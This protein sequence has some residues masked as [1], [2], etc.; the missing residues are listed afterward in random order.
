[1]TEKG[2]SESSNNIFQILKQELCD[3]TINPGEQLQESVVCERFNA[4][5]PPVRTAF[6]RLSDLGLVDIIPYRGVFS[7]L[8]DLDYIY[9]MIHLRINIESR[10]IIDFIDSHP[11]PLILEEIEHNIRKQKILIEKE[12]VNKTD[13]F[14]LDS[15]MHSI[16]F[17]NRRCQD[18]WNIIQQQEIH[19]TRFR[20]LD[21][22]ETQKYS[23][24]SGD[25]EK[26][27]QAIKAEKPETVV[28]ILGTHLNG[29][30]RRMGPK[31][32]NEYGSFFKA[33]QD[34]DFWKEYNK[35]YN[36]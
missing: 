23:E 19:Y 13:Y 8:L 28:P 3:L 17:K 2:Q 16:W 21:F 1:M 10:I 7:S 15:E 26:L 14:N 36:Y 33:P 32:L 6:Q 18:L 22:V 25:H 34:L 29:G 35:R 31:V 12:P 24:I 30:L 27:L 4:S 11:D 20:I 9:Q 5:R